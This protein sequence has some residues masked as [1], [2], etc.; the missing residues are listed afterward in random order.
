MAAWAKGRSAR[1]LGAIVRH[2][3]AAD[4]A[5]HTLAFLGGRAYALRAGLVLGYGAIATAR[6]AEGLR[7][8]RRCFDVPS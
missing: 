4:V 5:V 7:R 8:L 3:E 2:A 6:I 1:R